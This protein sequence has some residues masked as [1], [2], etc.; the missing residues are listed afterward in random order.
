MRRG[1]GS[2][3]LEAELGSLA[4]SDCP[5]PDR[6]PVLPDV[7][8]TCCGNGR[9]AARA[10]PIM[11]EPELPV[12]AGCSR[13]R[14]G[15]AST[16]GRGAGTASTATASAASATDSDNRDSTAAGT[17]D[18]R[19][20]CVAS[21]AGAVGEADAAAAAAAAAAAGA[22]G[23]AGVDRGADASLTSRTLSPQSLMSTAGT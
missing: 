3:L 9:A 13:D 22:A 20:A 21:A 4:S 10:R 1:A 8:S 17:D 5:G 6:E 2:I 16:E 14:A 19:S 18:L 11:R 15:G 7:T 23:A 12:A